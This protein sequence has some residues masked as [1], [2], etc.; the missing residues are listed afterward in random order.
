MY[1]RIKELREKYTLTQ[2]ELAN[3][4]HISKHV[5]ILYETGKREIPIAILSRLAR[6]FNTSIDYIVGDTDSPISHPKV[7]A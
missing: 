4:L 1:R 5:Y 7:N 2:E 6:K 3:E